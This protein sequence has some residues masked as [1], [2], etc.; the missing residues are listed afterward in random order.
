MCGHGAVDVGAAVPAVLG[1]LD[2]V[3]DVV[4]VADHELALVA[5]FEHATDRP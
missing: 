3:A 1:E 2:D 4:V 5:A